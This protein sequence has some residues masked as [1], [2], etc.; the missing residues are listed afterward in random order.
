MCVKKVSLLIFAIESSFFLFVGLVGWG[1]IVWVCYA[2]FNEWLFYSCS[3]LLG[4]HCAYTGNKNFIESKL[5]VASLYSVQIEHSQ[6]SSWVLNFYRTMHYSAKRGIAIACRWPVC[7]SVCPSVTL[8]DKDHIGEQSWKLIALTISPTHS[9]FVAQ[10][11]PTDSQGNMG[12]FWG[13]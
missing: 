8:V 3:S 2:K 12:K 1:P 6:K 5:Y 13:D 9:L 11:P 4:V 7:P 10:R